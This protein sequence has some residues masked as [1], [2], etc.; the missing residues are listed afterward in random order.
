MN[1]R[2]CQQPFDRQAFEVYCSPQCAV[3]GNE[4]RPDRGTNLN[5]S[6]YAE[7]RT[8]IPGEEL[9]EEDFQARIIERAKETGWKHY[10]TN[11]SRKSVPNFPDL[12]LWKTRVVFAEV[13]KETGEPT[14]GQLTTMEELKAAGAE[15]YLW[16]PSDWK[17]ILTILN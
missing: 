13:K 17:T 16:R 8:T 2:Y 15:V 1:C 12:V 14:A 9:S 5:L 6:N 3:A 10:H 11:N 4:R 7:A